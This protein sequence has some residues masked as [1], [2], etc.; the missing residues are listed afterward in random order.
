MAAASINV[1]DGAPVD[2]FVHYGIRN[3]FSLEEVEVGLMEAGSK[4]WIVAADHHVI[5]TRIGYLVL[6]PANDNPPPA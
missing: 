2:Q 5:L 4:G 6:H 3:G 1:G